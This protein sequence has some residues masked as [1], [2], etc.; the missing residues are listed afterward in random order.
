MSCLVLGRVSEISCCPSH[1]PPATC[2]T[3]PPAHWSSTSMVHQAPSCVSLFCIGA[4][5]I[6]GTYAVYPR[7]QVLTNILHF[8]A[9]PG[10][11]FLSLRFMMVR[12]FPWCPSCA[13]A[14]ARPYRLLGMNSWFPKSNNPLLT[15]GSLNTCP[16]S[17]FSVSLLLFP[18]ITSSMSY[19]SWWSSCSACLTSAS[20]TASTS[21]HSQLLFLFLA[22][23]S[24]GRWLSGC[25]IK[26]WDVSRLIM[27]VK[28]EMSQLRPL[29]LYSH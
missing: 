17:E 6:P 28:R 14:S 23:V 15:V 29:S 8:S 9:I 10:N 24:L 25:I 12:S 2:F 1:T 7:W 27:E 3:G 26:R 5:L 11:Q 22:E 19:R 13:A 4:G 18:L 20:V 21:V 16:N